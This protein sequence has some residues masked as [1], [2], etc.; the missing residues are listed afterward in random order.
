YLDTLK[1][2]TA[3]LSITSNVEFAGFVKDLRH[4]EDILVNSA[5]AVA[6]YEE[7]NP[8]TNFTYYSDQGKI[9]N[10]LGCGLPI[11][12]SDVP[13]IAKD[14]EKNGCGLI[15]RNDPN[16]IGRGII[17]LLLD[18]SKL[19]FYRENVLSYREKFD[20]EKIFENTVNEPL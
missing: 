1:K 4:A 14:L 18:E 12:L 16:E 5:L 11:L 19:K 15:I 20:W 13:P 6:T 8:E 17:E 2:I 7:G 10:Y 3:E 9:K